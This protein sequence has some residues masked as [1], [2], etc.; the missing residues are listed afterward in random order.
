MSAVA[1]CRSH[2]LSI[3]VT[4][5]IPISARYHVARSSDVDSMDASISA[6]AVI[7]TL[8][9]RPYSTISLV[10]VAGHLFRHHSLAA[11]QLHHAH[12]SAWSLSLA[13]IQLRINAIS[14][15][16]HLALCQSQENVLG[17]M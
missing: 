15:T 13:G 17:G 10:P 7:A 8:A 9:V 5:W 3:K 2:L 4:A 11:H 14:G 16:A 6:T 1:R 12:I